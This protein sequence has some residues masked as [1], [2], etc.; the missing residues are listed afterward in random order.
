[1]MMEDN[2]FTS[3]LTTDGGGG[4]AL[5]DFDTVPYLVPGTIKYL[6]LFF[7]FFFIALK[8]LTHSRLVNESV[9]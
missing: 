3:R 5:F 4:V 6:L 9:W 1:M 7:H 8:S 2:F